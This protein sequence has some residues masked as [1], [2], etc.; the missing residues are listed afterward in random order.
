MQ[1]QLRQQ[2]KK[3]GRLAF[4]REKY[5]SISDLLNICLEWLN[6]YKLRQGKK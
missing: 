2:L 5:F 3:S 4:R 6:G 1:S